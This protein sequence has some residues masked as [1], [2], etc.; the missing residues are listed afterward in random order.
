MKSALRAYNSCGFKVFSVMV[1]GDAAVQFSKGYNAG[2]LV[3]IL[4]PKIMKDQAHDQR[5]QAVTFCIESEASI[6]KIGVA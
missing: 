6:L 2:N 4:N 3:A 5:D 1:F